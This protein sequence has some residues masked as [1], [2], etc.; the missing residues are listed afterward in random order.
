MDFNFLFFIKKRLSFTSFEV[1]ESLR[2][3]VIKTLKLKGNHRKKPGGPRATRSGPQPSRP[4]RASSG[5]RNS[6][7]RSRPRDCRHRL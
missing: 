7:T 3:R 4:Q 1:S 2:F 5:S 6:R